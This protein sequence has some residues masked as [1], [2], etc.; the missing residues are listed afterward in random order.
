MLDSGFIYKTLFWKVFLESMKPKLNFCHSNYTKHFMSWQSIFGTNNRKL[1]Y[2]VPL[3]RLDFV[4]KDSTFTLTLTCGKIWNW[5][6]HGLQAGFRAEVWGVETCIS[7]SNALLDWSLL[8]CD[9]VQS[10][11]VSQPFQLH[12]PL[13]LSH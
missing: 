4:S 10:S 1:I 2:F 9:T 6:F 7:C 12:E 11:N 5:C 8:E 3:R 13:A